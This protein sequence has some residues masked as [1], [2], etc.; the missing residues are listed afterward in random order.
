MSMLH[1]K[2]IE[3]NAPPMEVL[4]MLASSDYVH[5]LLAS[6]SGLQITSRPK[7]LTD[8][9]RSQAM[10]RLLSDDIRSSPKPLLP[11]WTAVPC[12]HVAGMLAIVIAP[13]ETNPFQ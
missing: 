4:S 5:E 12:P 2:N 7:I 13:V 9:W 3:C 6:A 10:A 8:L 1:N 11:P